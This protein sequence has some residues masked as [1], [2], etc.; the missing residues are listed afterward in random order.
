MEAFAVVY[1]DDDL[2]IVSKASGISVLAERWEPEQ[3]SL[4]DELQALYPGISIAH[5]IDKETSGLLVCC[6]HEDAARAMHRA[7]ELREVEKTYLALA[8]GRPAWKEH[9]CNLPILP[10]GDREH[11]SVISHKHGKEAITQFRLL[12]SRGPCCLLEARPLTGRTHQIR[13]HAMESG[14]TLVGDR[15]YG[16]D[17][18]Y[19]SRIKNT[20]RGDK[21]TERPLLD[22]CAL[23]AASIRFKHPGNG[24]LV[25]LSVPLPQDMEAVLRQLRKCR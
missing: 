10:D 20:Y 1:K 21:E 9:S 8:W 6:L 18:L 4:C 5:R 11:R 16:G 13:V 22:R 19:L 12:E 14:C 7:F 24:A 2:L 23:H 3:R 17:A 15:L 25:E